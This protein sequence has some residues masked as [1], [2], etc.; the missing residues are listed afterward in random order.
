M[1]PSHEPF[2]KGK[3]ASAD[4]SDV[5]YGSVG[6]PPLFVT[7]KPQSSK[8]HDAFDTTDEYKPLLIP[9]PRTSHTAIDVDVDSKSIILPTPNKPPT[10]H[11][12]FSLP[13]IGRGMSFSA[14]TYG[15]VNSIM[16]VPVLY[17][18]ASIIFRNE[19]YSPFMPSLSKLCLFSSVVHQCVFSSMSTLPFAIGQVQDAGLLFLSKMADIIAED[20]ASDPNSSP[21]EAVSTAIVLLGLCTT[22]TGVSLIVMGKLK[23]ARLVGYIPVPV[24][25]GYLAFIGYFCLQAGVALCIS[26]PMSTIESWASL[27]DEHALIL[28]IPGVA[29]GALFLYIAK[30]LEP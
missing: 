18:Y 29:T 15:L 11:Q 8:C 5:R 17:G 23:L 6:P 24:V 27:F 26:K 16:C 25:G 20:I 28:A 22:L 13:D 12:S 19:I 3:S 2:T 1:Q 4:F 9:K 14:L 7:R 30:R 10:R 21:K